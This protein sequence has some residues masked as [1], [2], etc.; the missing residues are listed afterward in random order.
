MIVFCIPITRESQPE[1][2]DPLAYSITV[3]EF[4]SA[5][6]KLL[7]YVRE[8]IILL[9]SVAVHLVE[10]RKRKSENAYGR[11]MPMHLDRYDDDWK[12]LF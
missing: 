3:D 11:I 5:V 7:T 6:M 1:G 2:E 4:K 10:Q 12:Q 9:F 8:G